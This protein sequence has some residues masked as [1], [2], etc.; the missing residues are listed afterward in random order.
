MRKASVTDNTRLSRIAAR[1]RAYRR[2]KRRGQQLVSTCFDGCEID[3]LH[4]LGY[5]D[6]VATPAEAVEA[7]SAR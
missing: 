6:R 5:F 1:M 4:E 3:R 2:R 7:Y